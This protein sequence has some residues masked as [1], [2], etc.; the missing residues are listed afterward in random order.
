[1][2]VG[3]AVVIAEATSAE[4]V[5][6][7]ST[8]ADGESTGVSRLKGATSTTAINHHQAEV[9][10]RFDLLDLE[11]HHHVGRSVSLIEPRTG[12]KPQT[13]HGEYYT[14][15]TEKNNITTDS[16]HS[17]FKSPLAKL[18]SKSLP[19]LTRGL[20]QSAPAFAKIKD[21]L[22]AVADNPSSVKDGLGAEVLRLA[23]SAAHLLDDANNTA[24]LSTGLKCKSTSSVPLSAGKAKLRAEALVLKKAYEA[25]LQEAY[26]AYT[27]WEREQQQ[28]LESTALKTVPQGG[29]NSIT[30]AQ[31][32]ML[33]VTE[34][35]ASTVDAKEDKLVWLKYSL[36]TGEDVSEDSIL[37][38]LKLWLQK[39]GNDM[40]E[41]G[42]NQ[43][44]DLKPI[45]STYLEERR[46]MGEYVSDLREKVL[47]LQ[48][49]INSI[50]RG[51][52]GGLESRSM[53]V[54]REFE[55]SMEGEPNAY[56]TARLKTGYT[57]GI[58]NAI[59]RTSIKRTANGKSTKPW[60]MG[61]KLAD[62][63]YKA[64]I[65]E[66]EADSIITRP[67]A[68]EP[69]RPRI[70]D[71]RNR[72]HPF[73]EEE[74]ALLKS[75]E[76]RV[77][78]L[79]NP[80]FPLTAIDG[81]LPSAFQSS[82][83]QKSEKKHAKAGRPIDGRIV[84]T[85]ESLFFTNYIPHKTYF[86]TLTIRNKTSH[87]T[88]FRLSTM[89]P[90]N[91]S[92]YF[93]V[94][95]KETP[96]RFD[97]LIASG[98]SCTYEVLFTP[99][100]LAD[101]E[102]MLLVSTEIGQGSPEGPYSFVVPVIAK[103][104]PPEL[105]LSD[106]LHCGPCRAGYVATRRWSFKNIGGPGKFL[107]VRQEDDLDPY[108]VFEM[109]RQRSEM[110]ETIE[111]PPVLQ[112]HFEVRPTFFAV[113]AGAHGEITV[114]YRAQMQDLGFSNGG[115]PGL[116]ERLDEAVLKIACDNC[117]VLEL[118]LYGIAQSPHVEILSC[119]V[120]E[121]K[122]VAHLP[123]FKDGILTFH[124]QNVQAATVYAMKVQ[125]NSRIRLSFK[126]IVV[127]YP[128]DGIEIEG[129]TWDQVPKNDCFSFEPAFGYLAPNSEFTFRVNFTPQEEKHYNVVAK[130]LL[131][132]E[133]DRVDD[134]GDVHPR[135]SSNSRDLECAIEVLLTGEG[136]A[137]EIF[138]KP[139]ILFF[140][141]S[142]FVGSTRTLS[143]FLHNRSI[144]DIPY[145]LRTRNINPRT[146]EIEFHNDDE[147][148]NVV[149]ANSS[150]A[151]K[152]K[153]TGRFP[154]RIWGEGFIDMIHEIGGET[155]LSI[156]LLAN[157]EVKPGSLDFGLMMVDFGLIA[158]GSSGTASVPL[159]NQSGVPFRWRLSVASMGG[160]SRRI[161][162]NAVEGDDEE[163]ED[164]EG[165]WKM[166]LKP[167]S[168]VIEA[169]STET[170]ILTFNP[171]IRQR[172]RGI[173]S[174][175]ILP[176]DE[177]GRPVTLSCV[178]VRAEVQAPSAKIINATNSLSC[179]LNVPFIWTITIQNMTHLPTSFTWEN[180][181]SPDFD[182]SFGIPQSN[183]GPG[184]RVEVPVTLQFKHQDHYKGVKL[185]CKI[186][187]MTDKEGW[188]EA[189]LDASVLGQRVKFRI[190]GSGDPN[191][192]KVPDPPDRTTLR[193]LSLKPVGRRSNFVDRALWPDGGP[194]LLDFGVDCPIFAN[195]S[196]TLVIRNRSA[197][198]SPFRTWVETYTATGL[199]EEDDGVGL[200]KGKGQAH[201][202]DA[203]ESYKGGTLLLSP[204]KKEKIG[205][206]SKVGKAWIESTKAVR[207]T[208]SRMN[209]LLREG[210]GA[211]FH[212]SPS[213]GVIEPF[214]EVR[215]TLTSYN[216]LVGQYEDRFVCE[217]GNIRE[218]IP[219][220]M[221]VDGLPVRFTGA[222]LVAAKSSDNLNRINFGTRV[223]QCSNHT[224]TEKASKVIQIENLSPRTIMLKWKLYVN[225]QTPSPLSQEP[226]PGRPQTAFL[227]IDQLTLPEN[228]IDATSPTCPISLFPNPT[229][230]PAFKTVQ[231]RIHFSS[232]VSGVYQIL[233]ASE[234]WYVQANGSLSLSPVV[235]EKTSTASRPSMLA[236]PSTGNITCHNGV[237]KS[238]I[239]NLAAS[240]A[241]NSLW[242]P[243]TGRQVH[244]LVLGKLVEPHLALEDG[245]EVI[246]VKPL[247][248]IRRSPTT[249]THDNHSNHHEDAP[250]NALVV[251][252]NSTDASCE[253]I[254]TAE[255]SHLVRV[256]RADVAIT[257]SAAAASSGPGGMSATA[258]TQGGTLASLTASSKHTLSRGALRTAGD[259]EGVNGGHELV[260]RRENVF[261]RTYE[262]N[263]NDKIVVLVQC[264]KGCRESCEVISDGVE[265]GPLV[266]VAE[267]GQ[268]IG[269]V[270]DAVGHLVVQYTNGSVQRIPI[271]VG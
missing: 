41:S 183:L 251:L 220:F 82:F 212:A 210:R 157:V 133:D 221:G 63:I 259:Y 190:L 84:S 57:S 216:N 215:I 204:S 187:G 115:K 186:E 92:K 134:E 236:G 265:N 199:D 117:Q 266:K 26:D 74:F 218:T 87:A 65:L 170:C 90:Y 154:D 61:E 230:I 94:R 202:G 118:P 107:I 64:G 55:V 96:I 46:L 8:T 100:S 56:A 268:E 145:I 11:R 30:S 143:V 99:D 24:A 77:R 163:I 103:R 36:G 16:P 129:N 179:F 175:D 271:N 110:G 208:I 120:M 156:P 28:T 48:Q 233:L 89:P 147:E 131:L 102:L 232:H 222:Q 244:L 178:E 101:F 184:Q 98:M 95:L 70:P 66:T 69:S 37:K 173:L 22:L 124:R 68:L 119:T 67:G 44:T 167:S 181:K 198:P 158:L 122:S 15:T 227:D 21:V 40:L 159:V 153:A 81:P 185:R 151:I 254:V 80:R 135:L 25:A 38:D 180:P 238:P 2:E 203:V 43:A 176:M 50:E 235:T 207:R 174:C 71:K 263:P 240:L 234:I 113:D 249:S 125:N 75:M 39:M 196:I 149:R 150:N 241:S 138:S 18:H 47:S 116:R 136:I 14:T 253:F 245:G 137:Y 246:Q 5:I 189:S 49:F 58:F 247:F 86:K 126:W 231:L 213:H 60:L 59:P 104:E 123:T 169:N 142:V 209:Y 3:P 130:L 112:G 206:S 256:V 191:Q 53:V 267:A 152:L 188:L 161:T 144:S 243:K 73:T 83:L 242:N 127:D 23:N 148:G 85:P 72:M 192:E 225:R 78:F 258:Y 88:R 106:V 223:I 19:S 239:G 9:P 20:L 1:M 79:R 257:P 182:V 93:E 160:V 32:P 201:V 128:G 109:L 171:S 12:K 177:E 54:S 165:R 52:L 13:S 194:F 91:Y 17:L 219:I 264:F 270:D 200:M 108:S 228:E 211:A 132:D 6:L 146:M 255:P 140:T 51:D 42:L 34:G 226:N 27:V 260:M 7:A 10:R 166:V 172:L 29:S 269:K 4:G 141:G 33:S 139:E 97:G 237:P 248:C 155:L 214:G 31:L 105:T 224:Y 164:V 111:M 121:P 197:I 168:G 205:F 76:S 217:V 252:K 62:S 162:E 45:I 229:T 262:L 250:Q 193:R 261:F 195:R 114:T 35:E